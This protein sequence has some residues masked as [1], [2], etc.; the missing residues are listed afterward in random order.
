MEYALKSSMAPRLSGARSERTGPA[1]SLTSPTD[2]DARDTLQ[3]ETA[4]GIDQSPGVAAE[5]AGSEALRYSPSVTARHLAHEAVHRSSALTAQRQRIGAMFGPIAQLQPEPEQ[6]ELPDP[7]AS[8]A[9]QRQS[10]DREEAAQRKDDEAPLQGRFSLASRDEALLQTQVAAEASSREGRAA[11]HG[12]GL[13]A[14]LASGIESLSGLSMDHITV[15]RN[16]PRPAQLKAHAYAQGGDI[17]LAPGQEKHLPHEAWHVVQQ[18]QGRVKPTLQVRS[19]VAVNDDE[20]LEREATEMGAKALQTHAASPGAVQRQ[21]SGMRVAQR[22]PEASDVSETNQKLLDALVEIRG[23]PPNVGAVPEGELQEAIADIE[24]TV[25]SGDEQAIAELMSSLQQE[26]AQAPGIEAPTDAQGEATQQAMQF[27]GWRFAGAIVG[28][29]LGSLLCPIVL[30]YFGA[31]KGY[32]LGKNW[33]D[34][35]ALY[36]A[37]ATA[38]QVTAMMLIEPD[39]MVLL[40]QIQAEV[41]QSAARVYQLYVDGATSAQVTALLALQANGATLHAQI[42][43]EGTHSPTR[44]HQLYQDGA[45]PAQI[46]AMLALEPDGAT[47]H[48]QIQLEVTHSVF[49]V[50]QLYAVDGATSA[51]ITAMLAIEPNGP[52]LHA[53]IQ[54]EAAHSAFLMH[55]LYVTDGATSAQ[56]TAMLALEPDGATLHAQIQ[57]E[58]THSALLVHQLYV[59][60]GATS[61]Q[62]TAMLAIEHDGATLHTQIQT[63]AAHSALLVH[64][65]YVTDGATSAQITAMLALEPDGATLH[66]QIQT[67]AAH[68]AL[69]VHQ[70]YITDGAT[71]AQITGMLVIE[72]NGATLHTQIQAEAAQSAMLVH[73]LYVTDGA[74]SLQITDMLA[75]EPDGTTLHAQIQAEATQ[76]AMLVHQLYVTDGATSA[77]ITAMLAALNNGA[78]LHLYAPLVLR[79]NVDGEAINGAMMTRIGRQLGTAT[80]L[81]GVRAQGLGQNLGWTSQNQNL[82]GTAFGNWLLYAGPQPNVHNGNMNC[83]EVLLFG[84]FTAGFVNHG[85]LTNFYQG[86]LASLQGP[87]GAWGGIMN[88]PYYEANLGIGASRTYDQL[89]PMTPRPMR[90]DVVIF[91]TPLD[92]TAIALGTPPVGSPRVLSL[93]NT[94]NA[95]LYL[96]DVTVAELRLVGAGTPV[97]FFS[98][99]WA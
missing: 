85:W 67:E 50:H 3:R 33:D 36:A 39:P 34:I 62:I 73:Q 35:N 61:A 16:S 9:L 47:L 97:R 64:Q 83:W 87:Q 27:S 49:R 78:M 98:P 44:V 68:S 21:A 17:H 46:T 99:N 79:Q 56:I 25:R 93:W 86:M 43:L 14:Q 54:T 29:I 4:D 74:T 6:E 65:L 60:N 22:A 70:L 1:P 82:N 55:Q 10:A 41:A 38:P 75:L 89:D 19:Q 77:Q 20:A 81:E 59:T 52:A 66:T 72:T 76:S 58:A 18:A 2:Q 95:H 40:T 90:G 26:Q 84:A 28:G 15:H 11:P 63:E 8:G 12:S 51:Q 42:Q 92:H 23:N 13:P 30:T 69:L 94:P 53:Q 96:Q 5:A 7:L 45:L 48:A 91:N 57:T 37:G 32:E 71:S 31:K 24:N 80:A 88:N